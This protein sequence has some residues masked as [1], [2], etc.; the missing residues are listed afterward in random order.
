MGKVAVGAAVVCAVTT[1]T[2]AVL[3]IRHWMKSSGR[4]ARATA[5]LKELLSS[6]SVGI[7]HSSLI[8]TLSP[9][10]RSK[11]DQIGVTYTATLFLIVMIRRL[12]IRRLRL[13]IC[14]RRQLWSNFWSGSLSLFSGSLS[15][16]QP[17]YYG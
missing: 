15:L 1:C 2:V 4:W 5:I 13:F 6:S 9:S 14:T 11:L 16:F 7:P 12:Q 17:M 10:S 3:I 8:F